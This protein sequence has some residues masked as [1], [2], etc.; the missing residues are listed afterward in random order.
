MPQNAY[1]FAKRKLESV[2]PKVDTQ[3]ASKYRQYI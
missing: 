1:F 3:S 2:K